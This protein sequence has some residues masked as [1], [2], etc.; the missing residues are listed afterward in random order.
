MGR[1]S[2]SQEPWYEVEG[3]AEV[4]EGVFTALADPCGEAA[5]D[6]SPSSDAQE[7]HDNDPVTMRKDAVGMREEAGATPSELLTPTRICLLAEQLQIDN[8]ELLDTCA[9]AGVTGKGSSLARVSAAEAAQL[10][11][12]LLNSQKKK[13]PSL[14]GKPKRILLKTRKQEHS[15]IPWG[16]VRSASSRDLPKDSGI[17][18]IAGF[19]GIGK[20][21][22]VLVEPISSR[23]AIRKLQETAEKHGTQIQVVDVVRGWG[24]PYLACYEAKN[25][26]PR[27]L[28]ASR[29]VLEPVGSPVPGRRTERFR[30]S[31]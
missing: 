22:S 12:F 4:M 17:V 8:K 18:Q 27:P 30:I 24:P 9:K 11:A 21:R 28:G 15:A 20:E 23:E 7:G 25:R 16:F 1:C 5:P 2:P 31:R 6:S 13:E 14:P 3:D 10:K 29:S 19:E 26:R